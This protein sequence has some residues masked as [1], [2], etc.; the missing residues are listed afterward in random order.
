MEKYAKELKHLEEYDISEE[1][2]IRFIENLYR[3][4]NINFNDFIENN[5]EISF[6]K[7]K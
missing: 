6:L 1:R 3:L 5:W 2:K 7:D 4:A